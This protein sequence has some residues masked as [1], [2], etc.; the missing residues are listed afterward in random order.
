MLELK[1][2]LFPVD[3]SDKCKDAAH[4][5]RTLALE[6]GAEVILL[7]V[8]ETFEE[9][10]VYAK[11]DVAARVAIAKKR[12]DAFLC[13]E[14]KDLHVRPVVLTGYA[15][16]LIVEYAHREKMDLIMMPTHGYGMFRRFLLGSVTSKVLHDANCPVWTGTHLGAK[17][18][19]SKGPELTEIRK[20]VCAVD[21]GPQS[22]KTL[23]LASNLAK[24][25]GAE[26][27]LVHA[28]PVFTAPTPEAWPVGWQAEALRFAEEQLEGLLQHLK[29]EC[30]VRVLEGSAPFAIKEAVKEAQADLLVI[31]RTT[32]TGIIGR[33]SSDAYGILCHS[34]CSVVSV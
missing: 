12:L 18:H 22:C 25:F 34:P 31:G 5:V 8:V 23:Q 11:D 28:I 16:E 19:D 17:S 13:G 15:A 2:I 30:P 27:T 7:N 3:F 20:I 21:L 9:E 1:R 14:F 33:L 6:F 10:M 4:A 26:I 29:M 24:Q 32:H